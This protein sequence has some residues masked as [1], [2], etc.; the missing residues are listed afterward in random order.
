VA[1]EVRALS[2][3]RPRSCRSM[4]STLS[5][6]VPLARAG[7][8]CP[9]AEAYSRQNASQGCHFDQNCDVIDQSSGYL[10]ADEP[11]KLAALELPHWG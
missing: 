10:L 11:S 6:E 4:S 2:R 3:S 5:S 7:P 9:R 1:T 8:H